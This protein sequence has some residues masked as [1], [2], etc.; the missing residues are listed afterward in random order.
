MAANIVYR[1]I[2]NKRATWALLA[3][4]GLFIVAGAGA[5]LTMEHYGHVI[6]GMDNRI[7]W[8]LPHV[9]AVFLI[10]AA[11]GALN[12][13]STASVFGKSI[14]KP[15]APLSALLALAL[16]A[17]GLTV[18]MLDLGRPDRIIVAATTYNFKSVFAWNVFLYTGFFTI[19]GAYLWMMMERRMNAYAKHLGA[20]A[21]IWRLVLTTG[22]GSIF[23]FL[24]ARQAYQSAVLAPTF[25]AFSLSY[26]TAIYLLVLAG[27]CAIDD[28]PLGD[29]VV[30]RLKNLLATFVAA[31]LYL[32]A[33]LHLTNLYFTR[34]HG[35]ENFIL[36]DGGIFTGLFWLGQV[37]IG[38][39]LPL[40]FLLAPGVTRS[41]VLLASAAVV[42][43]GFCQM[44][45][46]IIG[47]QAW[48][49]NLF[50]GFKVSSSFF[51]G[52]VHNY[53]PSIWEILLGLGGVALAIAIVILALRLLRFLP[54][55]L[56]D[57]TLDPGHAALRPHPAESAHAQ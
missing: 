57:A 52:E 54:E 51:D 6:T 4:C 48:P 13:A 34:N 47:G 39:V 16:L 8:G 37:G 18:L 22:T 20:A 38:S 46:T 9:F 30:R 12:V 26:G 21:F 27:A 50:P 14:Y 3:L 7:V 49:L 5:H 53:A 24:V 32:V 40:I 45:V 43:G 55:R 25:I 11:S 28:R 41:R 29:A 33:V 17:G 35:V 23:G 44:Y 36:M 1:E 42:I 15:L 31:S 56:D 2:A 19:V 10:V